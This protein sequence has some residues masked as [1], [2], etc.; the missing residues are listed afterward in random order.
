MGLFDN[1]DEKQR[2]MMLYGGLA[3]GG[4]VIGSKLLGG[5]KADPVVVPSGVVPP[6]TDAI[7]AGQLSAFEDSITAALIAY[8]KQLEDYINHG[9]TPPPDPNATIPAGSYTTKTGDNLPT[10]ALRRY[11]R[12]DVWPYIYNANRAAL[13][14]AASAAQGWSP[15]QTDKAFVDA[16][17]YVPLWPGITLV[18]T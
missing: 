6:S 18:L 8:Q 17:G 9:S 10:I 11:S 15:T 2:K 12:S 14:A 16:H 3:V 5:Q 4:I 1:L 13:T 7:G